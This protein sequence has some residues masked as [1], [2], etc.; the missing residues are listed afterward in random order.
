MS[1][2]KSEFDTQKEPVPNDSRPIWDLVIA[3]INKR[4]NTGLKKY[5]TRLQAFNGRNSILDVYEEL[6]DAVVYTRQY[7]EERK[8]IIEFLKKIS[9][10]PIEE[11]VSYEIF[12][13]LK[14]LGEV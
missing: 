9:R 7:M 5:G 11:D 6:L 14:K 8:E 13:L 4:D 12:N 10:G 3:D 1:E 2:T